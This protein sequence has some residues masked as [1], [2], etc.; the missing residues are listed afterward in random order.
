M[1]T[2][3]EGATRR[4]R[5]PLA[6][7]LAGLFVLLVVSVV[8]AVTFGPADVSTAEAFA[9]ITHHL[10]LPVDAPDRLTDAIV[11]ELRTP[12][13]LTAAVV[14]AGLGLAGAVMQSLTRNPLAD[15]YLLG[16]SSG[17]SLGAV[18][19][20]VLGLAVALPAAAFVGALGALALSLAI[21]RAAGSLTP[22]R[23]VLAGLAV[24]QLCA[25]ATSVVI[26]WTATGDSYREIVTWLLGSV[27]GADWGSVGLAA[28]ALVVVGL[29]LL[30]SA[31]TLDAFAF[32]DTA[33]AS[34]GVHVERTRWL[35][36]AAVALLTGAMVAVSGA[37]GFVGLVLPHGVRLVLGAPHRRLL[38]AVALTG[39]VF[40]VWADTLARTVFDPRELPVGVVT[41]LVGVPVF[42]ILL[43]RRGSWS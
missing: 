34:L 38:P 11:W 22:T 39:A 5:V 1:T 15:P 41:A 42:V 7:A 21:A 43:R 19:V 36:L 26:F 27:A 24:S 33:A 35:L 6:V 14:G 30:A 32:G 40:L 2:T 3:A 17:A 23:M 25:A 31:P 13:T 9:S 8:V 29:V 37:I 20:L 16:L 18:A 28:V 4:A 12:R 10:G